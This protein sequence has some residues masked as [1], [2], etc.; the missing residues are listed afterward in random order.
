MVI[1][2]KTE[3]FRGFE[4]LN[5][6]KIIIKLENF[7]IFILLQTLTV[8]V[9]FSNFLVRGSEESATFNI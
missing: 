5:N 7:E 9:T 2:E 1:E 3:N 4:F 8:V 6:N